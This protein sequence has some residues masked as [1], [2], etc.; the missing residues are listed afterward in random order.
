M[1]FYIIRRTLISQ[2]AWPEK[3]ANKDVSQKSGIVSFELW[4]LVF[5][6]METK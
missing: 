6:N 2:T 1:V 4:L 5:R 3:T